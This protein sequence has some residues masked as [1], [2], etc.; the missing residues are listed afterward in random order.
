PQHPAHV[1]G[2]AAALG[3][4]DRDLL[5]AFVP[6]LSAAAALA[7]EC[8]RALNCRERAP[9]NRGALSCRLGLVAGIVIGGSP[10]FG[11]SEQSPRSP[12]SASRPR[13]RRATRE[14]RSTSWCPTHPVASPISRRAS[15]EPS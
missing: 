3:R 2:A 7:R 15:S 9:C 1:R 8:A 10:C 4:R 13:R 6:L 12:F 11:S 14:S 5:R